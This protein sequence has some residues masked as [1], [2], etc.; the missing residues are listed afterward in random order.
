MRSLQQVALVPGNAGGPGGA[1]PGGGRFI[2]KCF[3]KA[4][5]REIIAMSHIFAITCEIIGII[6]ILAKKYDVVAMSHISNAG[7]RGHS[8]W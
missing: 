6:H 1:A 7:V 3:S 8:P 2:L 4:I 5:T